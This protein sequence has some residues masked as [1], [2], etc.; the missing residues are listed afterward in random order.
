[1][2]INRLFCVGLSHQS[3]PIELREQLSQW[4]EG[5]LRTSA[6]AELVI[7]STCNR[8]ELYAYLAETDGCEQ[9]A[10]EDATHGRDALVALMAATQAL[11]APYFV[12][13]LYIHQGE[14]AVR[15]LCRVAAGLESLVFVSALKVVAARVPKHRSAPTPLVSVRRRSILPI[16]APVISAQSKFCSSA[17]ARSAS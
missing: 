4:P 3:A 13:H 11:P 2:N 8:L 7:V 5:D 1:M 14:A 15:H 6:I 12:D 17:W 9:R 16:N 10:A